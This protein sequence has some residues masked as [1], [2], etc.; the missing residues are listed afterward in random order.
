MI[1]KKVVFLIGLIGSILFLIMSFL[2]QKFGCKEDVLFFCGDS[3]SS[4]VNIIHFL[5]ISILIL[6]LITYKMREEVFRAWL[7]FTYVWVPLTIL[8]TFLAPEYNASL[9]A[10]TKS[11]VSFSM[12]VVFLL[13]SLVI[14]FV[15]YQRTKL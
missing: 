12:S 2:S 10:T 7:K 4:I 8:F 11:L 15:K 14:I 9:V 13:V 6:S 3:Y 1:N 5:P